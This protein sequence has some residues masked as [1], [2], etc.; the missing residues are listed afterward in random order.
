[1]SL[2]EVILPIKGFGK[3]VS[4][5]FVAEIMDVSITEVLAFC[6]DNR[7]KI[8]KVKNKIGNTYEYISNVRFTRGSDYVTVLVYDNP[9]GKQ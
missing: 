4:V 1:M 6:K 7:F 8:K 9:V 3:L 5:N 2:G